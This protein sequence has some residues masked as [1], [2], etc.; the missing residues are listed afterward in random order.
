MTSGFH[1]QRASNA[2]S[3]SML[4]HAHSYWNH[5]NC[6]LFQLLLFSIL[7]PSRILLFWPHVCALW[8]LDMVP[9]SKIHGA[10]M[11]P[12]CVLLA[13]GG[14]HVGPMNLAIRGY[15]L[16]GH[17]EVW[18]GAKVHTQLA[19]WRG[20]EFV[21]E[22]RC[23]L[24]MPPLPVNVYTVIYWSGLTTGE[25]RGMLGWSWWITCWSSLQDHIVGVWLRLAL[26]KFIT[27]MSLNIFLL[28]YFLLMYVTGLRMANFWK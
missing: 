16:C 23:F 27:L 13:P 15:S 20:L 9:D 4:W 28:W 7:A 2:E 3:P 25:W 12:T 8:T 21:H 5:I 14:P 18:P 6:K 22:Y 11:G 17:H 26:S 24:W 1:S 19:W 10:N